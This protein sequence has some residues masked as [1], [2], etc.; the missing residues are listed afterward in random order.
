MEDGEKKASVSALKAIK[1][2]RSIRKFKSD[3][4]SEMEKN[5]RG[6]WNGA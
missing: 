6:S 3:S 4:I 1:E 2:R 5:W